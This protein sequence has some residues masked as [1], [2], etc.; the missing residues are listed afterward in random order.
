[1]AAI[2]GFRNSATVCQR[3]SSRSWCM[4]IG[5]C[6]AISLRSAPAANALRSPVTITARTSASA[7]SVFR[8]SA[9][10]FRRERLRAFRASGRLSR[11]TAIPA[12][13]RSH[14]TSL[15][16][17]S[18]VLGFKQ[19]LENCTLRLVFQYGTLDPQQWAAMVF[20]DNAFPLTRQEPRQT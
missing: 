5:D 8:C 9:S 20:Q 7:S 4:L 14:K 17:L 12:S 18:H 3:R 10:C 16:P 2:S 11:N 19:S 13:G 1:M 6:S 15:I